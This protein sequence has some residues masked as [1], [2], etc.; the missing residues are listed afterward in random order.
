MNNMRYSLGELMPENKIATRFAPSPSGHLHLGH[1]YS[2]MFAENAALEQDGRF[3]L[4]MENIDHSR[5]KPVYEKSIKDDLEWLGL[6]WEK[7]VRRQS[8]H[9]DDYKAVLE[10][11][12][13]KEILYPCF[14]ARKDVMLEIERAANAPHEVT[15]ASVGPLYPGTCRSLS[16]DERETRI[17]AKEAFSLRLNVGRAQTLVG[18]I[19]WRDLNKGIVHAQ[20]EIFGDMVLAR[21]DTP[22]SY[23]LS[24]TVDDFLQKV[25]LVTRGED[26]QLVT[27]I[28]CLL[29]A[30]L[31]YEAPDYRF[32]PL[33][34]GEDGRRYSKRNT[35]V[36]LKSLRDSGKTASE[37][38][39]MVGM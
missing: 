32:H 20:P 25:S 14:C 13:Q 10:T 16:L 3:L 31:G 30:L 19:Q 38:R 18:D 37:I 8:D 23:H 9:I 34:I 22:T 6:N 33:L 26:L 11:L 5:C 35:S 4:R 2:A 1:A 24:V 36:T 15:H 17:A 7:P 39:E 28:H 12:N 27:H 21:K 29:Q